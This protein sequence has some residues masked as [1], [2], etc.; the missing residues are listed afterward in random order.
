MERHVHVHLGGFGSARAQQAS[1]CFA[2]KP[3]C[4]NLFVVLSNCPGRAGWYLVTP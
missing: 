1:I 2:F 4:E 3:R